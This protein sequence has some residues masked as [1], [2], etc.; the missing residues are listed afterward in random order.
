MLAGVLVVLAG[1]TDDSPPDPQEDRTASVY[2]AIVEWF[3]GA[4]DTDPEPLPVFVEP[5]GDGATIPL[6]A[7]T[8]LIAATEEDAAV[9]F[10]DAREEALVE[11]DDGRLVAA[12]DGVLLRLPP[13]DQI[14]QPVIADVDVHL[15]DDRF[16]T[17]RFELEPHADG[18]RPVGPPEQIAIPEEG[19]DV[20]AVTEP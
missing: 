18:W 5:R 2:V 9:R 16:L 4:D 15:Q 11:D 7:Q 12:D 10:I 14:A 3:A 20:S 17:L 19:Q 1:C 8:A 6:E 13:V